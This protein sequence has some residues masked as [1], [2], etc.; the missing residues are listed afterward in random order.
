MVQN[1][2]AL[3]FDQ[4]SKWQSVFVLGAGYRTILHGIFAQ[5]DY[6]VQPSEIAENDQ[7]WEYPPS[8]TLPCMCAGSAHVLQGQ[9]CL[10]AAEADDRDPAAEERRQHRRHQNRA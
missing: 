9:V 2:Q 4:A 3:T 8:L 1:D 10:R 6:Q 5:E 7:W